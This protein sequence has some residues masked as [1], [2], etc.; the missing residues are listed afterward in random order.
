[1]RSV[2]MK[3]GEDGQLALGREFAGR[4]VLV[5]EST[6]GVWKIRTGVFIP[7]NERWLHE[8]KAR[9]TLDEAITWAESHPRRETDLDD[10][11]EKILGRE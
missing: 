10:L 9:E 8:P 5:E 4:E 2:V 11:E 1:M 3:V 6:P 7:D